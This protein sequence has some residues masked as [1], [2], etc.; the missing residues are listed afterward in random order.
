MQRLILCLTAVM[1]FSACGRPGVNR[2]SDQVW[3]KTQTGL[4][5]GIT[6]EQWGRHRFTG[7]LAFRQKGDELG[8]ALLDATGMTLLEGVFVSGFETSAEALRGPMNMSHIGGFM[9]RA[10]KRIFLVEPTKWPCSH[11][12]LNTLCMEF[13]AEGIIRKFER[14]GPFTRWEVEWTEAEDKTAAVYKQPW[15]GVRITLK[16]IRERGE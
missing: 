3:G 8:F 2:V 6:I 15:T 4:I 13:G 1:L 9:E 14:V 5:S 16:E 10:L 7:L 12:M 11:H